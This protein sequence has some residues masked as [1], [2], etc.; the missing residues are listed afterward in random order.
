MSNVVGDV[1]IEES[2]LQASHLSFALI[3][4]DRGGLRDVKH[5]S[6]AVEFVQ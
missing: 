5:K 6:L 2:R 3:V 4:G 1:E